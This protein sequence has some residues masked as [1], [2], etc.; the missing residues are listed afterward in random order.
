MG[1]YKLQTCAI[2]YKKRHKSC[3][4]VTENG[5]Y[6]SSL[7]GIDE[8]PISNTLLSYTS[9]AA[10]IHLSPNVVLHAPTPRSPPLLLVVL[11]VV[12]SLLVDFPPIK[13]RAP[14][15]GREE[16]ILSFLAVVYLFL[17]LSVPLFL[18]F[19]LS[20]HATLL[21]ACCTRT[22]LVCARWEACRAR[23]LRGST[24]RRSVRRRGVSA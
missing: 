6:T 7:E 1:G 5:S 19:F 12:L 21:P 10:C 23:R 2:R 22:W 16:D 11:V 4:P 3:T 18:F 24:Q 9:L 20:V 14:E 15:S 17:C 13:I 8:Y